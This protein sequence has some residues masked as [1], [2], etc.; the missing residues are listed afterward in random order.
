MK[1]VFFFVADILLRLRVG[2]GYERRRVGFGD[3]AHRHRVKP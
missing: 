2:A 3:S 1:Y